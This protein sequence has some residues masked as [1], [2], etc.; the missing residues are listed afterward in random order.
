MRPG[1][2]IFEWGA[3][4][5]ETLRRYGALGPLHSRL[6]PA[7]R[8]PPQIP[9][10]ENFSAGLSFPP[11]TPTEMFSDALAYE[12]LMGRWSQR[13]APLFVDFARVSD[14]G[15]VLDVG[16]GTGSLTRT[17]AGTTRADIVGIDPAEPFI[18][19][20]RGKL[21]DSRITFDHGSALELP[22]PAGSFASALSLLVLHF[23]PEPEKA[24]A[25]MR[26]VTRPGGTVAACTWDRDG[27]EMS[28]IFWD[29]ASRLDPAADAK[30]PQRLNRAGQLAALW[31]AAGLRDVE[32]RALEISMDFASF[33]DFWRPIGQGVGPYG[34][35]LAAAP[36][37]HV[38]TLRAA[39]EAR[40]R[41]RGAPGAFSLRA[42]A[43]AVRGV[44]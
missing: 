2:S 25:E 15:R 14:G 5:R 30:R 8:S 44:A 31:Q 1:G 41:G 26:R 28:A 12:E 10:S 40:L 22:Y 13:L 42:K 23:I 4:E 34:A 17:L 21:T 7:E 39:L 19:Y 36:R 20:A 27:L 43:L 6:L 11:M 18:Q 33:A 37:E 35:H 16:C 38:E 32:E 29:E 3:V 24:A 9:S